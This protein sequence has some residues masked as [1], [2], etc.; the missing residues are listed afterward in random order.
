MTKIPVLSTK[1]PQVSKERETARALHERIKELT[2]LYSISRISE[3]NAA[4]PDSVFQDI[5]EVIPPAWQYPEAAA[6]RIEV[7]GQSFHSSNFME[8]H[9]KLS[10]PVIAEEKCRGRV[11]VFYVQRGSGVEGKKFLREELHLI[12][13]IA[14]QIAFIIER[15]QA[16]AE[17][18]DLQKQLIHADRL[19]T[20]GQLAAGVAHELNE[21]LSS[22]LGFAQLMRKHPELPWKAVEDLDKIIEASL[23]A[24]EIIK[25][26]LLFA[27]QTPTFKGRVNFNDTVSEALGLFEH[28]LKKGGIELVRDFSPQLPLIF[29]DGGQLKQ[30]IVNLLV[31]AIQAMPTGGI[32]K[33]HTAVEGMHLLCSIADTGKGMTREILDRIFV[34]FFTTKEVDQG[35]GLG[36]PV[37]HGIVTS[38]CGTISVKSSPGNG[39]MFTIRLPVDTDIVLQGASG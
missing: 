20:I 12:R 37:V 6:A 28:R 8:S 9:K 24:R 11:E 30:V 34:P 33:V 31:N 10:A 23:Y 25:K 7:D 16:E 38:H 39:A 26:L 14:R 3:K 36:L 27:R 22:I 13:A 18:E 5:V 29:A 35:T 4:L 32:L 1:R 2:C 17:K 19:A 21:P 15:R